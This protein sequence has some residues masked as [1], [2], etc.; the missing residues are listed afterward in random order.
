MI[1][2]INV[3]AN[4]TMNSYVADELSYKVNQLH[5]ALNQAQN[6]I[7]RLQ[8]ENES[9]KDALS[10]LASENNEDYEL[11]NIVYGCS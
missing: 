1:Q 10:S 4:M 5:K 11:N 9:L 3:E 2:I 6:I 8:E 7:V